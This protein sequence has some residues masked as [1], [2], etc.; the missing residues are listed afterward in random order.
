MSDAV[1]AGVSFDH[2]HD[3]TAE[4]LVGGQWRTFGWTRVS[5]TRKAIHDADEADNQFDA[6][7]KHEMKVSE[8]RYR[9][10]I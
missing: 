8:R 1:Q 9:K 5:R 4:V 7:W 6:G 3:I 2:T 10:V